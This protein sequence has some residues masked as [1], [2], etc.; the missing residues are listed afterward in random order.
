MRNIKELAIPTAGH[1]SEVLFL[2]SID[3]LTTVGKSNVIYLVKHNQTG[4]AYIWNPTQ[5]TYEL[6][7]N[8]DNLQASSKVIYKPYQQNFPEIG[9]SNTFY[10]E[11]STASRKCY[12]WSH[13]LQKYW[14]LTTTKKEARLFTTNPLKIMNNRC[15]LPTIAV[16]GIV[17]DSALIF[18]DLT[19]Q[20]FD[21]NGALLKNRSY[22]VFDWI[23][24]TVQ[25]NGRT[26]IFDEH[27]SQAL[28]N[29]YAVMSYLHT[30]Y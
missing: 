26:V 24:V 14:P 4:Y 12:V 10:V 16:G 19:P 15:T 27:D 30:D 11:V 17:F 18:D 25:P 7:D 2:D 1:I 20:D 9:S 29:K 22:T 3:Q 21:Q 6:F 28:V 5:R 8:G 23:G 13:R